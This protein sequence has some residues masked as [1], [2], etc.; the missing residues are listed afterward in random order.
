MPI[1]IGKIILEHVESLGQNKSEFARRIGV[2]PQNVYTVFRRSSISTDLLLRISQVLGY[3]FF[4]YYAMHEPLVVTD[5]DVQTYAS[6]QELEKQVNEL[7]NEKELLA[8]ENTYLKELNVL[9]RGPVTAQESAPVRIPVKK[10]V[11]NKIAA[12]GAAKKTARKTKRK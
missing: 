11:K 7:R 12:P 8:Q 2:T 6:A 10:T 3:N 4:Q 5:G 9:L 1:H